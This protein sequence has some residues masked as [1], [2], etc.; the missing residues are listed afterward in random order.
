MS[1]LSSEEVLLDIKGAAFGRAGADS[2]RPQAAV[3]VGATL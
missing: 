1:D 3:L 2:G